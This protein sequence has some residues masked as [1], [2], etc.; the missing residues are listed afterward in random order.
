MTRVIVLGLGSSMSRAAMAG[1]ARAFGVVCTEQGAFTMRSPL[2]QAESFVPTLI[3][4]S[5]VGQTP[6]DNGDL[7]IKAADCACSAPHWCILGPSQGAPPR[8]T[9]DPRYF[10]RDR[11]QS[12]LSTL[13]VV[14]RLWSC[15]PG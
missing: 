10:T 5:D 6:I 4:Q 7:P 1:L 8:V 9:C 2:M 14:N 15:Q 3:Y 12:W 11:R 13:P